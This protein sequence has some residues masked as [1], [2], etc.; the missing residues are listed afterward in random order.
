MKKI[1]SYMYTVL[2]RIEH[3]AELT[4]NSNVI[5][6]AMNHILEDGDL[7]GAQPINFKTLKGS[8][9][10]YAKMMWSFLN[11]MEIAQ[12]QPGGG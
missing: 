5:R 11:E 12:I 7:L 1:A 3:D 8:P 10:V 9:H 4:I 6:D 2:A